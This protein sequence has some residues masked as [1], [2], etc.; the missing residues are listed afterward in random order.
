M[1]HNLEL[2]TERAFL[3][4]KKHGNCITSEESE[5]LEFLNNEASRL[6]PRVTT[7]MQESLEAAHKLVERLGKENDNLLRIGISMVRQCHMCDNGSIP[8]KSNY[9]QAVKL[10]ERVVS[11]W[12]GKRMLVR[13][14][15]QEI[16]TMRSSIDLIKAFKILSKSS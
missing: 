13:K 6:F 8:V 2:M 4:A 11:T 7:E 5:R 3:I 12:R 14:T 10:P 9:I 15:K 16:V 1:S